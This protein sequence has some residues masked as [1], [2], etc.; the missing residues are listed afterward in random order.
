M[1]YV[2]SHEDNRIASSIEQ[3]IHSIRSYRAALKNRRASAQS[4][5]VLD[6]GLRESPEQEDQEPTHI[7]A[8]LKHVHLEP[9]PTD[10]VEK[11][12]GSFGEVEKPEE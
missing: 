3:R 6:N 10:Q 12:G 8:G 2:Y 9:Q 11:S 4:Q 1:P 5:E 7:A